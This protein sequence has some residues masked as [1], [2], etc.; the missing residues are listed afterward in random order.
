MALSQRAALVTFCAVA[1][2]VVPAMAGG[3]VELELAAEERMAINGRQQWLARLSQAGVENFRIRSATTGERPK[4]DVH[5]TQDS[6]IYKVTGILTASDELHLPGIRFRATQLGQLAG[7]IRDLAENG[8][9][10]QRPATTAFGLTEQ[11]FARLQADM[12]PMVGF[13]TQGISRTEFIRGVAKSMVTPLVADPQLAGPLSDDK[14]AEQLSNLSR[15]TAL[16]YV[17]RPHGLCLVPQ[18]SGGK[19]S[20]AIVRAQADMQIWPIGW[21]PKKPARDVQPDLYEFLNVN[22]AG[23]TLPK[24]LEVVSSRLEMPILLDH[25]AMARHG[26]E[27]E[28]VMITL[29][30]KRSTYSI[31]LRQ[32]LFKARLKGELRVD[33]ADR[34]FYW[35][36]TVKPL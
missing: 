2:A 16:A 14:V 7:W 29:P 30:P 32:A 17:L 19:L 11:D 25:N 10:D 1:L 24:V 6:P 18:V 12:A 15:G 8:P 9:H 13:D 35:V 27:P 26:I 20:L 4:I 33:E 28:S 22:V 36:T 23:V 21:E 31:M 3:R 34:P 5:G